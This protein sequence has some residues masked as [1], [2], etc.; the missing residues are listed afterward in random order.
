MPAD[1]KGRP[2]CTLYGCEPTCAHLIKDITLV[3]AKP[4]I[5]TP[6]VTAFRLYCR[7]YDTQNTTPINE[8]QPPLHC[9]AL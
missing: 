2:T 1:P 5:N 9:D 7:G 6:S 8:D 3:Y 4:F